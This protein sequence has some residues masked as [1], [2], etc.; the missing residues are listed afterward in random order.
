MARTHDDMIS[1]IEN[2]IE[3]LKKHEEGY[4][5]AAD[6]VEDTKLRVLFNKNANMSERFAI[7]LRSEIRRLIKLDAM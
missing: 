6:S 1:T 7:I 4:R 3:V 5:A 2:L